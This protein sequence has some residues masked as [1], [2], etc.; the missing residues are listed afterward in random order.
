[1]NVVVFER[2]LDQDIEKGLK[3]HAM[4]DAHVLHWQRWSLD[5]DHFVVVGRDQ[6]V[7][8]VPYETET[9]MTSP[10]FACPTQGNQL[11]FLIGFVLP[12][13]IGCC[14]C[15]FGGHFAEQPA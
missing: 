7:E 2:C 10:V 12:E 9:E 13:L 5:L 8:R 11:C 1:M 3:R 14:F 4:G 6:S 15:A